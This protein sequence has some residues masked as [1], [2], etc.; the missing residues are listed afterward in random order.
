MLVD[1]KMHSCP[2]RID[3]RGLL[4]LLYNNIQLSLDMLLF[5][6]TI[7]LVL[8]LARSIVSMGLM[9][10]SKRTKRFVAYRLEILLTL[11]ITFERATHTTK[12]I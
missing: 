12:M 2:E 5:S 11:L 10:F 8:L 6:A 1:D 4:L 7:C 3:I 9:S